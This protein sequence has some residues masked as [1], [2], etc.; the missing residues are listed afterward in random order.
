M[1]EKATV[2]LKGAGAFPKASPPPSYEPPGLGRLRKIA[3]IGTA[4]TM[5]FAPWHDPSWEIWAHNSAAIVCPRVDR[6]FDL[7]PRDFIEIPKR[8]N[9]NYLKWLQRCPVP[10]YMQQHY[11]DI[12]QSVRYPKERVLA[13]FRR[14]FSSQAAW[15]IALA[16]TEGVTHLGFFGIHYAAAEERGAQRAGC[17]YWM[18]VAEGKG[19][20]LVMPTGCPLLREPKLLY[21]YENYKN[22]KQVGVPDPI[23]A[24]H[25]FN[26]SKL[27]IIDPHSSAPRPP[28]ATLPQGDP[29][30]E[31]SGLTQHR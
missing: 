5:T 27:T 7:H 6:I 28:L 8:W 24:A 9:K 20:Q 26:P 13:E 3:L 21:G 25:E 11:P 30:W 10:I 23:H 19:V 31:R 22:G 1:G 12:P 16:L 15:M 14:Y 29:A 4:G 18:G 17:E 2:A